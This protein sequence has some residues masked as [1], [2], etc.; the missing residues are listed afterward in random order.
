MLTRE[1]P[2]PNHTVELLQQVDGILKTLLFSYAPAPLDP[3]RDGAT[4]YQF[5]G[6]R[7]GVATRA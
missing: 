2:P 6:Y 5:E 3:P 7:E 4:V 1:T